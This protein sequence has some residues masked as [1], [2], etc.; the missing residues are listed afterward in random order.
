MTEK[1]FHPDDSADLRGRAEENIRAGDVKPQELLSSAEA[2]R[3]VHELQ[4]HQIELAMQN[5]ELRGTQ[6]QLESSRA[7]YFDLYDLAPVG[8]FTISEKG[9]ILEANVTG[10]TLL[11]VVRSDLVKQP[12]TRFI[13]PEDQDIYYRHRKQLLATYSP[14]VCELRLIRKDGASFWARLDAAATRDDE[15]G[16]PV[17]RTVMSDITERKAREREI[18]RLNRLY[19][20]LSE[21]NQIVVRVASREELFREVCRITTEKAGFQLA[22]IGWVEK[23]THQV[24]PIARDGVIQDYLDEIEVYA[25]DRPEGRGPTGS[26]I[27][28]DRVYIVHDFLN[29]P[30][31]APW[32]AAMAKHGFRTSAALPIRFQGK[33]VGALTAYDGEPNVIQDKE[34]ALL[35]E[36]AAAISLAL[37]NLDHESQ[38]KRI[39]DSLRESE[40]RLRLAAQ[41][42]HFGTYDYDLVAERLYWSP[43]LKAIW[44]LR[45]DDPRPIAE[46]YV[47]AGVHPDDWASVAKTLKES[48]HPKG[49]GRL[50]IEHRIVRPDGSVRWVLARGQVYFCGDGETR[51]AVRAAGTFLDITE[52]KQSEEAIR[53][54]EHF[55]QGIL[56]ATAALIYIYDLSERRNVYANR[57]VLDFLGYTPEELCTMGPALFQTILHPDDAERV[58]QH[59]ARLTTTGDDE[60]LEIEYRM[61]HANGPWRW[62]RSCDVVFMRNG[63]G[64]ARQILGSAE[65]ITHRKGTEEALRASEEKFRNLFNNAEVGMFRTNLDGSEMLD[66]NDKYLSILGGSREEIVGKPSIIFWADAKEREAM[67]TTLRAEGYVNGFECRLTKKDGTIIYCITSLRLYREQGILEGSILDITDRKQAEQ[68]KLELERRLLHAQKLESIGILAGGIAHDFNNILAGIMGYADLVKQQL[69]HSEPVQEDLDVIKKSVQRAADLTR[70]MLAYSGKGKFIVEPVSLSRIVDDSK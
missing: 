53:S 48:L 4:V 57:S 20:A 9:L 22:W 44:G 59:H 67:A 39:E 62:L 10:A 33:V 65:D 45:P 58:A 30:S 46:N 32:H 21:L 26:C 36:A 27:R 3:L 34:V 54:S 60:V 16:E 42:A 51:H 14:Q 6:G 29:D 41:A 52:R 68:E 11:G 37:E 28:E 64:L 69:P 1:Q 56:K 2:K 5:E 38:R 13:L 12:L 50:R 47:H 70:Q 23:E 63:H 7:R 35:E 18:E 17:I 40:E 8:Y 61:K 55:V 19:A 15:S 49:S 43:E 25:D 31:T 24:I 66:L